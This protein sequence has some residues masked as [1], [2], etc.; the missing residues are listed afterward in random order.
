MQPPFLIPPSTT[1]GAIPLPQG[2]PL[3]RR[4]PE[5]LEDRMIKSRLGVYSA[6]FLALRAKHPPTA[7]HCLRV[8]L[9]CSKW[10]AARGMSEDERSLLEVAALLHDVGK[11]GVP[12]RVLQKSGTLVGYEQTLLQ[13]HCELA[14]ELLNGASASDKLLEIISTYRTRFEY[15]S[16]I[17]GGGEPAHSTVSVPLAARMIAIVDAFDSMVTEQPFRVAMSREMAVA[18]LFKHAGSQFDPG[19]V[20]QFSQLISQPNPQLEMSVGQRWLQQLTQHETP[21][22]GESFLPA[23]SGT[24]QN[25]ID[26]LYHRRL[27]ETM[28][29]AII[30]VDSEARVLSWNH[31]AE[32]MTGRSASVML[33][34]QLNAELIGLQDNSG[35][36]LTG[37]AC[38]LGQALQAKIPATF[39]MRLLGSDKSSIQVAL[40]TLPVFG[41]R[42]DV[43]GA[44]YIIRDASAQALLEERVQSLH[45]IATTDPLTQV[46][47]RAE[48]NNSL[49]RFVINH[50][51]QGHP[52]SLIICDID[53]F[54]RIND[55]YGH[56]AGD[57]ALITFGEIL[58]RLAR[59]G[60]L[61]ARYGGE[62]FVLLCANCDNASATSRAEEI[63]RTVAS[64]PIA[65]LRNNCM[66]A[67]FGVTEIQHG[68]TDETLLARADRALLLAKDTGRNR[69][70]QLGAGLQPQDKTPNP[71]KSSWFS[72]LRASESKGPLIEKHFLTPVP[73]EIAVEKLSGFINDHKADVLHVDGERVSIRF[74]AKSLDANRRSCDRPTDLFMDV[75]IEQVD[76]RNLGRVK[77]LSTYT[78]FKVKIQAARARDRRLA[79]TLTQASHLVASFKSY[80][81]AQ[82]LTDEMRAQIVE[83]R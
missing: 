63:R 64:T 69:V 25:M 71:T 6:L 30:Y 54:K 27:L 3:T 73:K 60:D 1:D 2:V 75:V 12:D 83:P 61:V 56:Q 67:S 11:L 33:H 70:V 16:P 57:D 32:K 8:A 35:S 20:K 38:P 5:G 24:M 31:A 36:V 82:E 14:V 74:K 47:N 15:A 45:E 72:W 68:D 52:G 22:F 41:S 28:T 43:C 34:Q 17:D 79:N 40:H 59:D 62:E 48:L 7:A 29:D 46:S 44:I 81:L 23:S 42:S 4:K 26:T 10:A 18:E 19:L 53:H 55:T 65:S 49:P 66:T 80:L 21:G 9:G 37:E 13:L 51:N 39:E 76:V 78:R 77:G 58:K 50:L